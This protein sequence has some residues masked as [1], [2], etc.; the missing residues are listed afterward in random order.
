MYGL[1]PIAASVARH[2]PDGKKNTLRKSY[3]GKIKESGISGNFDAV[4]KELDAPDTLFAMM[5]HPQEEWDM[6]YV[7]GKEVE[8]GIPEPA[9]SAL[10]RAMTMLRGELSKDDW[11][12]K[13]LGELGAAPVA[14]KVLDSGVKTATLQNPAV[15][16]TAKGEGPRPKRNIRKR[17]YGDTSYEGYGEGYVDD[18]QDLQD[19]GYS[20]GDGDE[21]GAG[22]KR[23]KKVGS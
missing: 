19:G 23:K 8:K 3:K 15:A 16:R 2:F 9:R 18:E 17:T 12:N 7:R 21:R 4:K 10:S 6:Q 1:A 14:K 22:Q 20:T 5:Q 11:D 13:V